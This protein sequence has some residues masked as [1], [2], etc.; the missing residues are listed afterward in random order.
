MRVTSTLRFVPEINLPWL[1]LFLP[2][3]IEH[4]AV[5]APAL[6]DVSAF[7]P[8]LVVALPRLALVRMPA[9]LALL[10]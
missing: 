3:A 6:A 4:C 7:D 8:R 5:G 2:P 9:S 10:P 1:T